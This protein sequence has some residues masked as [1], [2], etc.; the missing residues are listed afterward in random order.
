MSV[1]AIDM[2]ILQ[3][4]LVATEVGLHPITLHQRPQCLSHFRIFLAHRQKYIRQ[5][6][7]AGWCSMAAHIMQ[8]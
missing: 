5:F 6:Y 3:V 4:V 1:L 2:H 8:V 7:K